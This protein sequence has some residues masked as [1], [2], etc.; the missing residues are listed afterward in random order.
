MADGLE[1]QQ[2]IAGRVGLTWVFAVTGSTEENRNLAAFKSCCESMWIPAFYKWLQGPYICIFCIVSHFVYKTVLS[3]CMLKG[4]SFSIFAESRILLSIHVDAVHR[5]RHV[6]RLGCSV[7]MSWNVYNLQDVT[8]DAGRFVWLCDIDTDSYWKMTGTDN[9]SIDSVSSHDL[10]AQERLWNSHS[11]TR[12]Q[13][14]ALLR[15][16]RGQRW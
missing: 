13:F 6:W 9:W 14:H 16:R 12:Q 10:L 8:V 4:W 15:C 11:A 3:C 5:G 1:F 2:W 7:G